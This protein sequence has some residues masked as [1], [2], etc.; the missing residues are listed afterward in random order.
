MHDEGGRDG[1]RV[2]R[3]Y[4]ALLGNLYEQTFQEQTTISA[5]AKT[6]VTDYES[7]WE[8]QKAAVENAMTDMPPFSFTPTLVTDA[9]A[10][11][12]P[13]PAFH[14][15]D[16]GAKIA[17]FAGALAAR[18]V[19]LAYATA[20]GRKSESFALVGTDGFT[21]REAHWSVEH[22]AFGRREVSP[23]RR[24]EGDKAN[25]MYAM[26]AGADPTVEAAPWEGFLGDAAFEL[27]ENVSK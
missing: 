8:W 26:K 13:P 14:A 16:I 12:I 4:R 25:Y 17:A 2:R 9:A 21:G 10:A 3:A 23:L 22:K 20:S 1:E 11:W 27:R 19:V 7:A 6:F 18:F 15:S 24:G 5:M